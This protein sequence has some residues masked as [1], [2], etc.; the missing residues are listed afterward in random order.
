MNGII[1]STQNAIVQNTA[2]ILVI[3]G[4]VIVPIL[5]GLITHFILYRILRSLSKHRQT[6]F[7]T[8]FINNTKNSARWLLIFFFINMAL[9]AI[10]TH[11]P[12]NAMEIFRSILAPLI[13]GLLSWFLINLIN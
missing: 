10:N 7:Y 13:I 2:V 8:S 9:P 11:I 4:I 6:I 5:L 3:I 1:M 12:E